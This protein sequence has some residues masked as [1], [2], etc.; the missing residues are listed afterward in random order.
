[1]NKAEEPLVSIITVCFNSAKTIEDTIQS[2][3][4]QTYA[5]IEY[6]VLDGD[7]T[8]TTME[9]VNGYK[10]IIAFIS[11]EK[12]KG[13]YDA[14]NKGI[15]KATGEIIGI[16]NADDFYIDE[17]VI[18]K[19]V[20]RMEEDKSDALYSDLY[21]VEGNDTSKVKRHWVSGKYKEG[22][23]LKGWMPPHP[24]FFVRK[25]VY[26]KYGSFNLDLKSAA[27]YE[28]ML[29]LIHKHNIKLSYLPEVIVKMRVGGMSNSSLKNRLKANREDKKAW[30]INGLKPKPYTLLFKPLRKLKQFVPSLRSRDER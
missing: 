26:E 5:N 14:L 20:E 1:M 6:L 29:R 15:Q 13:M 11:S 24:T 23:F 19:V 10:D 12:D 17:Y 21:Y 4:A 7:S 25:E 2:V 16:L 3:I 28:L 9:V 8:D 22:D 30:E 18:E 27:D